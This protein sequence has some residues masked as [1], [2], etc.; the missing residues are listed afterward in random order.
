V[1]RTD[2]AFRHVI[3]NVDV[4]DIARV[5]QRLKLEAGIERTLGVIS[6][7]EACG[8]SGGADVTNF[9][10]NDIAEVGDTQ[11]GVPATTRTTV[12]LSDREV[13]VVE[14]TKLEAAD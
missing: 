12:G 13:P 11:N 1:D 14:F 4:P 5:Y 2:P 3:A 8:N 10:V 6:R 7:E 9:A